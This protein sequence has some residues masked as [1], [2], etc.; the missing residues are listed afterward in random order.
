MLDEVISQ[1]VSV[2]SEIEQ[3][4]A[5]LSSTRESLETAAGRYARIWEGVP[6]GAQTFTARCMAATEAIESAMR[7]LIG[8]CEMLNTAQTELI[9]LG[10]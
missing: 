1:L 4:V 6:E 8:A 5:K 7:I 3:G 10:E 9:N 2:H